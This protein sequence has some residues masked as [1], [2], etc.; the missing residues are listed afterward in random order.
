[1]DSNP[2]GILRE[3][4]VR[5]GDITILATQPHPE[6]RI[7]TRRLPLAHL[8]RLQNPVGKT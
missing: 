7:E 4:S 8:Q 5:K 1:L 3:K 2:L 6:D